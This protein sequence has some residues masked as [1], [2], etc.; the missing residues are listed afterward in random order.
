LVMYMCIL[1]ESI[2]PWQNTITYNVYTLQQTHVP[3]RYPLKLMHCV[4]NQLINSIPFASE[5]TNF[6]HIPHPSRPDRKQSSSSY[7]HTLNHNTTT[8]LAIIGCQYCYICTMYY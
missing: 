3:E 8:I 5:P 1:Y 7:S 2:S 6:G 4:I